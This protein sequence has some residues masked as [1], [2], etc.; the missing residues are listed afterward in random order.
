MLAP[1][2]EQINK[3]GATTLGRISVSSLIRTRRTFLIFSTI[4]AMFWF[5]IFE[6]LD[7]LFSKN[8]FL[9]IKVGAKKEGA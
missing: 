2:C 4:P 7:V 5:D 3:T 9:R 6:I 1:R 8:S